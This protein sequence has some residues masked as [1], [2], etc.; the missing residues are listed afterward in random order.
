MRIRKKV[1]V[2][3]MIAQYTLGGRVFCV[4]ELEKGEMGKV[5]SES[6]R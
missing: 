5:D 2:T 6:N 4:R 1:T 3:T